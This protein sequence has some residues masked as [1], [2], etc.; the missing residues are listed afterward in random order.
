VKTGRRVKGRCVKRTKANDGKPKCKRFIRH[1][2]FSVQAAAGP[3]STP[4]DGRIGKNHRRLAPGTY[5]VSAVAVDL[6]G[7]RSASRSTTVRLDSQH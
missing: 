2:G 1:G 6:Q 5:R 4:F 7:N 3:G